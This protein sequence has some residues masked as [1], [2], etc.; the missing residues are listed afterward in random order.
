MQQMMSRYG[1]HSYILGQGKASYANLPEDQS[2]DNLLDNYAPEII[3][4]HFM[5]STYDARPDWM[6][7]FT[8]LPRRAV[9]VGT[10]DHIFNEIMMQYSIGV[11]TD[12]YIT[13]LNFSNV[14]VTFIKTEGPY[15]K[16]FM[17]DYQ[18]SYDLVLMLF[19]RGKDFETRLSKNRTSL[20][21]LLLINLYKMG[22]TGESYLE[23]TPSKTPLGKHL[24]D[25]IDAILKSSLESMDT[26]ED[27]ANCLINLD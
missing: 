12:I 27:L 25:D 13:H 2:V 3:P 26:D 1:G 9:K 20:M 5:V 8:T 4:D 15:M 11:S 23:F 18:K 19:I 17:P 7:P 6:G 14:Y 22:A 10:I 21:K 24:P 16:D